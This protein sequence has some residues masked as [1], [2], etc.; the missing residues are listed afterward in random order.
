MSTLIQSVA[1]IAAAVGAV[2]TTRWYIAH[3]S[4]KRSEEKHQ[5]FSLYVQTGTKN[6]TF[7]F[8][9]SRTAK[10]AERQRVRVIKLRAKETSSFTTYCECPRCNQFDVHPISHTRFK[11]C[12]RECKK[13][14][15]IWR[16]K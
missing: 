6:S 16:Q 1:T 3:E 5:A 14:E 10:A 12:W 15:Y 4:K 7:Y 8:L 13:C 2:K 9:D 11:S